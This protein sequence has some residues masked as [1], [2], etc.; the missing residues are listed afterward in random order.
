LNFCCIGL[1]FGTLSGEVCSVD[2]KSKDITPI[3][4]LGSH[5]R[6]TILGLC[7]L[8]SYGN[9]FLSGSA[10]GRVCCVN[11]QNDTPQITDF[12]SFERLTSIHSNCVDSLLLIS[13]Y[14]NGGVSLYDLQSGSVVRTF[15]DIHSDHI[16]IS[17]FCNTSPH[18]FSTSSFD[19]TIKTWDLRMP[20]P[21]NSSIARWNPEATTSS[22]GPINTLKCSTG[23]VT[24]HFSSDD[25]FLLASALDNEINQFSFADGRLNFRYNIPSTGSEAN[26]TRGYF[27][28]SG[29]YTLTGACEEST[30]KFLCSYT[31]EML[32][33]VDVYPRKRDKSLYIQSLRGSSRTDGEFCVL[34]N[35]HEAPF[36][37]LILAKCYPSVRDKIDPVI[38]ATG[39][40]SSTTDI[41]GTS[42]ENPIEND[43]FSL[44]G[45]LS[46]I[47][48]MHSTVYLKDLFEIRKS[49]GFKNYF[50]NEMNESNHNKSKIDENEI[51]SIHYKEEILKNDEKIQSLRSV[52]STRKLNPLLNDSFSSLYNHFDHLANILQNSTHKKL[53]IHSY[54]LFARCPSLYQVYL[55]QLSTSSSPTFPNTIDI[56]SAL[57][58]PQQWQIFSLFLDYLY[59]GY[60]AVNFLTVKYYTMLLLFASLPTKEE[61]ES[62]LQLLCSTTPSPNQQQKSNETE[63]NNED[64]QQ[65]SR[66]MP[67]KLGPN[68]KNAL[69]NSLSLVSPEIQM[70]LKLCN[71]CNLWRQSPILINKMT[72]ILIDL[73]E[74]GEIFHVPEFSRKCE[75]L[76]I[77]SLS[78]I[79]C[80][81]ILDWAV[82][83][84]QE[85]N[86]STSS[87]ALPFSFSSN[88]APNALECVVKYMANHADIIRLPNHIP[89]RDHFFEEEENTSKN[90]ENY[91]LLM[92]SL[93]SYYP[94]IVHQIQEI[95]K[96]NSIELLS[97]SELS[98][99]KYR[100]ILEK[101]KIKNQLTSSLNVEED[102]EN[103]GNEQLQKLKEKSLQLSSLTASE[104][105]PFLSITTRNPS[106]SSSPG[107][108]SSLSTKA[109]AVTL[110]KIVGHSNVVIGKN[111]I[112]YF[113]GMNRER[114]FSLS[115]VLSY[116]VKEDRFR[117][118]QTEATKGPVNANLNA[119]F[120]L[121]K[122]NNPTTMVMMGG[123]L[124]LSPQ[125]KDSNEILFS[126]KMRNYE[127]HNLI[128][129]LGN[130]SQKL[131][132]PSSSLSTTTPNDSKFTS[133]SN[134]LQKS[135]DQIVED[136]VNGSH[137]ANLDYIF[138]FHIPTLTWNR[139]SI[140]H[141]TISNHSQLRPQQRSIFNT[142]P[143]PNEVTAES[144]SNAFRK[145][146]AQSM[147][148]IYSPDVS[149]RC[150][151][152]L[153]R[154]QMYRSDCNCHLKT[155]AEGQE[156]GEEEENVTWSIQFG[157]LCILEDT[158]KDDVHVLICKKN[159]S[160]SLKDEASSASS[161]LTSNKQNLL[162]A[163]DYTYQWTKLQV[164]LP[165]NIESPSA[166]FGHKGV[167]IP[168]TLSSPDS[169]TTLR[170][171]SSF[172]SLSTHH[173][174]PVHQMGRIFYF[175]G[176]RTE[177]FED[178]FLS[179]RINSL[180][181]K[182]RYHIEEDL[183]W[184][185][186]KKNS[187]FPRNRHD[188][189]FTYV[190][191]GNFCLLFGG[192]VPTIHG[193]Q[194]LNDLWA[195]YWSFTPSHTD[196]HNAQLEILPGLDI[197]TLRW[198]KINAHGIPPSLRSRHTAAY[199]PTGSLDELITPSKSGNSINKRFHGSLFIFGGIDE[200]PRNQNQQNQNLPPELLFDEKQSDSII[201]ILQWNYST[202][203]TSP[204][205]KNGSPRSSSSSSPVGRIIPTNF[206]WVSKTNSS[207]SS[208]SS[209]LANRLHFDNSST[210]AASKN[211]KFLN[212]DC[213]PEDFIPLLPN[214]LSSDMKSLLFLS[215]EERMEPNTTAQRKR[216]LPILP[217]LSS[218][219]SIDKDQKDINE[220]VLP[221][222][223]LTFK[224]E[225]PPNF[226]EDDLVIPEVEGVT[227][228][229]KIRQEDQQEEKEE[230]QLTNQLKEMSLIPPSPSSYIFQSF[231]SF[232]SKRCSVIQRMLESE[233]I[234][235][236]TKLIHVDGQETNFYSLEIFFQFLL[237][238][239]LSFHS[240]IP[241]SSRVMIP[242]YE[243]RNLLQEI[244][245]LL[246][247]A[248]FY[249]L[250]SLVK[251]CEG[252]LLSLITETTV[253]EILQYA[254][255]MNLE[256][257]TMACYHFIF[258]NIDPPINATI[259]TIPTFVVPI[260]TNENNEEGEDEGEEAEGG[261]SRTRELKIPPPTA[262]P[263]NLAF[264]L[265]EDICNQDLSCPQRTEE[266]ASSSSSSVPVGD[267]SEIGMEN[268]P[269]VRT[270]SMKSTCS[271]QQ[272]LSL[273]EI[274][275]LAPKEVKQK[276]REFALQQ[277][278]VYLY[279]VWR[280]QN[281]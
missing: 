32:E 224:Y 75:N 68:D 174:I 190:S 38:A 121:Q 77:S 156:G 136:A 257:L 73:F 85:Q 91:S 180:E 113:G 72:S 79:N 252:L 114:F 211:S 31:G 128:W 92:K 214:T 42:K 165:N 198:E 115:R 126:E 137:D 259:D 120:V 107:S 124:K 239:I 74:L 30:V 157:G 130:P 49:L 204:V 51:I 265:R 191:H 213:C 193:H 281:M 88:S 63:S 103:E 277:V 210:G 105:M 148:P 10:K 215:T 197:L 267:E 272:N 160:T 244:I 138:E 132:S 36:R 15:S 149:Y 256:L 245:G 55:S 3:A 118:L 187:P 59:I 147:V 87:S 44:N 46:P 84:Y 47:S 278:H 248:K 203:T 235:S 268:S 94:N 217:A 270:S 116:D 123:K 150:S 201:S 175:G 185:P 199:L 208:S 158:I 167:F 243:E 202:S 83:I 220:V 89:L 122:S 231:S 260:T 24:I 82:R 12:P 192:M 106:P 4:H 18:I 253:M 212:I 19:G 242:G 218:S 171:S 34:A 280:S 62:F 101:E 13:G 37:E 170:K 232:L 97:K 28:A 255:L 223:D 178:I 144:L 9:R 117:Y 90:H 99:Q 133:N 169:T 142:P 209:S 102:E 134:P 14:S 236:K 249:S 48:Q 279:D 226:D 222:P 71:D 146:L 228:S 207:S 276:F 93:P 266:Q 11:L 81:L 196:A 76:L 67:A 70:I 261:V 60:P 80:V 155:V 246:Q 125:Q 98:L 16:N 1:I 111:S 234:E 219:S 61:K 143:D 225:I 254:D 141:L 21:P 241:S 112:F 100:Q 275:Q 258:R 176:V 64:E 230:D 39:S 161:L 271:E 6:D 182:E 264:I 17:R 45:I 50:P 25:N 140:Q 250:N 65:Q 5:L 162:M 7:W 78:P 166:R 263:K 52:L 43:D 163:D 139:K 184:E 195:L 27:S 66:G 173:P 53:M 2:L 57:R 35:Y 273:V 56:S 95:I 274:F 251:K 206:L 29:R 186:Y 238:D 164:H 179:L 194:S 129:N 247:L 8:K 172:S 23:V 109:I 216:I 159:S 183:S 151:N 229:T 145:R 96:E 233:M 22:C 221:E 237:S 168:P 110:P 154:D 86:Y 135:F 20:G 205:Q 119:A 200:S 54:I 269:I 131:L 188:H 262:F 152:C 58:N 108:S 189:S 33:T 69:K 104:E 227:I 240:L 40:K 153:F 177:N 41:V 181:M 26:F 127:N